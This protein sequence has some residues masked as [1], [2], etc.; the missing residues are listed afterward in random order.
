VAWILSINKKD[1]MIFLDL[2]EWL[3]DQHLYKQFGGLQ[4]RYKSNIMLKV[5]MFCSHEKKKKKKLEHQ[6]ELKFNCHTSM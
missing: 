2:K 6:Y 4:P 1:E 5:A 3:S